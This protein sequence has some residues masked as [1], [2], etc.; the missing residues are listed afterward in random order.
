MITFWGI[1][2]GIRIGK[3]CTYFLMLKTISLIIFFLFD[4]VL[5]KSSTAGS[6]N[7]IMNV[8]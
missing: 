6:N 3:I 7:K 2:I 4:F 8:C 1:I 5:T